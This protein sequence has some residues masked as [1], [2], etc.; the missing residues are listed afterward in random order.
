MELVAG[1]GSSRQQSLWGGALSQWLPPW[2]HEPFQVAAVEAAAL[3]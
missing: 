3:C 2:G 1:G